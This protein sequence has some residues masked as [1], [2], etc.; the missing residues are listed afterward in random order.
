MGNRERVNWKLNKEGNCIP[1]CPYCSKEYDDGAI[2]NI[3]NYPADGI[4]AIFYQCERCGEEAE[5]TIE[6]SKMITSYLDWKSQAHS[7]KY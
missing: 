7:K 3:K 1:S 5:D 4:A 2:F 6:W